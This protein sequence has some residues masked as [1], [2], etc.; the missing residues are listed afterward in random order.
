MQ[1]LL[2]RLIVALSAALCFGSAQAGHE[3]DRTLTTAA[4]EKAALAA[5]QATPERHVMIFFGDHEN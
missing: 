1:N 3:L 5:I 2:S 4:H